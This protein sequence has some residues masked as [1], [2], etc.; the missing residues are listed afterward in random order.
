MVSTRKIPEELA[1]VGGVRARESC[2]QK[3][4]QIPSR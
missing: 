3:E 1:G 4:V 2:L